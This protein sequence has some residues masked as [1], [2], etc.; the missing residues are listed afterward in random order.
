MDWSCAL[1]KALAEGSFILIWLFSLI[2]T[3]P[4]PRE[5]PSPISSSKIYLL[6]QMSKTRVMGWICPTEP[7]HLACGIAS[8]SW[9]RPGTLHVVHSQTGPTC[10]IRWDLA[11][12]LHG[13]HLGLNWHACCTQHEASRREGVHYSSS[14]QT[15]PVLLIQIWGWMGFY[16]SFLYWDQLFH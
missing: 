2:E 4:L 11:H 16:N 13:V 3:L 9:T 14:L 7:Y 10:W 1:S 6:L 8:R 15:S 5:T 12:I